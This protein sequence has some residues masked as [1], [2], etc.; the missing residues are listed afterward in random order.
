MSVSHDLAT[1][2]RRTS[3]LRDELLRRFPQ[4]AEDEQALHDTL[5][6][7]SNLDEQI[8]AVVESIEEDEALIAGLGSRMAHLTERADR[9]TFRVEQKK[10]V[11]LYALMESGT[12][13]LQLPTVT[14]SQVNNP[15]SVVIPDE[16]KVPDEYRVF[17]DPPSPRVDKKS[18][19]ADLKAGKDLQFAMLSNPSKRLGWYS[20]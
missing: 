14:L 18:I 6:G 7:L 16:E 15:P 2:V 13:K 4:L 9:L 5:D 10:A 20:K 1:E 17:P 12:A 19:L 8:A 3:L 11:I